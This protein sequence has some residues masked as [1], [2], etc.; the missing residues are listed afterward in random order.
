MLNLLD[1][2]AQKTA[3]QEANSV[4]SQFT[5]LRVND[6]DCANGPSMEWEATTGEFPHFNQRAMRLHH[7]PGLV[8][9]QELQAFSSTTRTQSR[10]VDY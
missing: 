6:T 5:R 2:H 7:S 8:P 1:R 3:T 10:S 9:V 4:C